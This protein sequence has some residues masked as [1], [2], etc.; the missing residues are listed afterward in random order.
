MST[1]ADLVSFADGVWLCPAPVGFLGMRL[2]SAM[3]LLRLGG[4]D[5]LVWSPVAL[6]P[7]RRAAVEALGRVAHLYAPNVFHHRWLGDWIAAFPAARVHAPRALAK[8]RRDLRIDRFHGAPAEPAFADLID[9][10]RIEGCR[11]EESALLVRPA[12]TALVADLVHNIGRPAHA[13]TAAYSR[14]MGF[15]DRVALSRVIR[16]TAFNDKTAARRALD[17]LLAR[18]FDRLIVGHGAPLPAGGREA[19]AAAYRWLRP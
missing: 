1:A 7:E 12:R 19:L 16:W 11:L 3:A 6:T 4:G 8:K 17:A 9:E 13:W 15:H 14:M 18:P 5:L 2:T 10:I